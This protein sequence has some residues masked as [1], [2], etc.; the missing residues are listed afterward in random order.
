MWRP[1]K[2]WLSLVWRR[3]SGEEGHWLSPRE[4]L[5]IQKAGLLPGASAGVLWP[6]RQKQPSAHHLVIFSSQ[7]SRLWGRHC[8][9]PSGTSTQL[10]P[11]RYS[12]RPKPMPGHL[13]LSQGSG[14]PTPSIGGPHILIR[15]LLDPAHWYGISLVSPQSIRPSRSCF[16]MQ[17]IPALHCQYHSRRWH[18]GECPAASCRDPQWVGYARRILLVLAERWPGRCRGLHQLDKASRLFQVSS[19]EH[20]RR[21]STLTKNMFVD[22]DRPL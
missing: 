22:I 6:E 3:Y 5:C 18:W 16:T 9:I 7:V 10:P 11:R 13:S 1:W 2:F 4:A 19:F 15:Q 17:A 14:R 21:L 20:A 12:E 8:G